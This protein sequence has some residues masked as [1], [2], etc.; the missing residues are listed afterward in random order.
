M[1]HTID[2]VGFDLHRLISILRDRGEVGLSDAARKKVKDN[3]RYLQKRIASNDDA[4]YGV[5]TGF[6]SLCDTPIGKSDIA[7]LQHNLVVSHACGM[8][9]VVSES[10]VRAM[11]LLK[12]QNMALGHSA[13][14]PATLELLIEL[15]NRDILPVIYERG[16]LGASGDL[17]PLAHMSLPLIGLGEVILNGKHVSA[18]KAL[19]DAGLDPLVLGAKEGLALLNGTQ[20]MSAHAVVLLGRAHRLL[21]MVDQVAALSMEGYECGES[22]FDPSIHQL[23]PHPGQQF[24]AQHIRELRDGSE[25]A[26]KKR[27]HVQDP[28]SF[29]CV[30][31]VHGATRDAVQYFSDVVGREIASVTDNP[32][33]FH[34]EDKVISGGNFHGQPLAIG[35]DFMAIAIAELGSISER[36]VYK[37]I[38]GKRGLPDFLVA[39]PGLNSGFMIPQYAAASLVSANKQY[40]TPASVDTI[41]SSNG[42]E[43][44]V[45]MGANAAVKALQV[46]ENVERIVAIELMNAAQA[47]EFRRPARS[48]AKLEQL[49]QEFRTHVPFIERDEVMHEH[50]E[51]AYRFIQNSTMA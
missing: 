49:V 38:S 47:I 46:L 1:L 48:S 21:D 22:P 30:P 11:M 26:K 10:V 15:Y 4:I 17:A 12:I 42:Q 34:E 24:V 36:R 33:V 35:L 51:A 13:V 37:L 50:M 2:T 9:E 3:F 29:R 23:R 39:Q 18:H 28:Y 14:A 19:K 6:G 43:D 31:Q 40:C 45:S 25:I 27:S 20:F 41:D 32:T 5:N 44:H 16:S 8:G 7:Q